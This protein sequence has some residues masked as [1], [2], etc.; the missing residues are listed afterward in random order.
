MNIPK[1]IHYCWFGGNKLPDISMRCIE[2]WKKYCPDYE[3]ILWDE[4]NTD[5]SSCLFAKEAYEA[6]KW[7]FV[8]DYIRLKVVEEHGGIYL[9]VDVELI[10]PLDDFITH[11]GFMGFE[12]AK[13]YYINTGLGFGAVPGHPVIKELVKNYEQSTFIKEDGDF[14]M[15]PCPKRDSIILESLGLS[16]DNSKQ[17][18]MGIVIYPYNYFCPIGLVGDENFT[19]ETVSIHHFNASWFSPK[20]KRKKNIIKILKK[21]IGENY[22]NKLKKLL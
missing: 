18:L 20:Q 21:V 11:E 6:E 14:D 13:P 5:L 7:A 8:S 9:D 12:Q 10:K 4:T 16:L 19:D 22:Y 2:S 1:K 3:I 15:L 17:V